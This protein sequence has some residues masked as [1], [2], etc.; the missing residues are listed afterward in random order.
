MSCSEYIIQKSAE[1]L[2]VLFYASFCAVGI[3]REKLMKTEN[4]DEFDQFLFISVCG[5]FFIIV[6]YK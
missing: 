6:F 1:F 4:I 3:K 5:F 2:L